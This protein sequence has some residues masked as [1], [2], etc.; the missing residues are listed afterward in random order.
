MTKETG[1]A[2][3][4]KKKELE[5][6]KSSSSE[7]PRRPRPTFEKE[8]EKQLK[9]VEECSVEI[10]PHWTRPHDRMGRRDLLTAEKE[11]KIQE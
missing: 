8:M 2:L 10:R 3:E 5:A 6:L 1:V 11:K 4:G 7:D 9:K